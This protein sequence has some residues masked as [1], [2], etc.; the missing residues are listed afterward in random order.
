MK[1]KHI[2][3][4]QGKSGP[5]YQIIIRYNI[6]GKR[7]A[8]TQ[9]IKARDFPSKK[10]AIAY[11]KQ[12]R[13]EAL[14]KIS[15]NKDFQAIP[16]VREM[17]QLKFELF[18]NNIKTRKKHDSIYKQC[19]S[20]YG[21]IPLDEITTADIQLCLNRF[22]KTH[23]YD[24]TSRAKTVWRQIFMAAQ[25]SGYSITDKTLAVKFKSAY[26]PKPRE[27]Q[28]SLESFERFLQTLITYN[29]DNPLG[30]KRSV[31]CRFMLLIMYYTG[32]RPAEALAICKSDIDF[33]NHLLSIQKA[34]GSTDDA[35]QQ[36]VNTKTVESVRTIP[37]TDELEFVL[38]ELIEYSDTAPLIANRDGLPYE[39]DF[40]SDY[41]HR[42]SKKAGVDFNSY[43]LRHLFSSE[44]FRNGE[45]PI[46]IRDL[47]G[48]ASANMSSDYAASTL[49]EQAL[50]IRNRSK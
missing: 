47:M 14:L 17:Y 34:V 46:V 10:H 42:V 38:R 20:S 36:I 43:M 7:K 9:T 8:F 27:K 31:D 30:R 18:G 40:M 19:I 48:H 5:S 4:R 26:V 33:G 29:I 24:L 45:N 15:A 13:N 12:V 3:E 2:Y 11:A 1:E 39:I 21:D 28:T 23:S 6:K 25:M 35:T 22:S 41:I 44:L 32:C 16:T 50:A 37:M 49:H